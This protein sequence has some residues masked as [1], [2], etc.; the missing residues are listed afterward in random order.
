MGL[1]EI[2]WR[3]AALGGQRDPESIA[4]YI[5]GAVACEQDE[6]DLIAQALNEAFL[7]QGHDTFP[8]AY[9]GTEPTS[10]ALLRSRGRRPLER[11]GE[12][13]RQAVRAHL[14]SAAAARRAASLH[15]TAAELMQASGHLQF[16]YRADARARAARLRSGAAA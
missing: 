11:A 9:H 8:V 3:Y 12:V 6:H 7:D 15:E 14:R 5:V 2:W 10:A 16:A 4:L 13:R 1:D